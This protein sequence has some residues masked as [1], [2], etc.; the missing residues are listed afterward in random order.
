MRYYISLI[1]K[2]ATKGGS[3]CQK[4]L[5]QQFRG[6]F[7][8]KHLETYLSGCFFNIK[9]MWRIYLDDGTDVLVEE[10]YKDDAVSVLVDSGYTVLDV[11]LC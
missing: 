1:E 8:S 6:A 9:I 3:K 5:N 11:E 4:G 10:W 7:I 2:G